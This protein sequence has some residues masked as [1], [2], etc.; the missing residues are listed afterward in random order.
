[1]FCCLLV[2][3]VAHQISKKMD[4]TYASHLCNS[5][6]GS[7]HCGLR[8]SC[9]WDPS[10]F[11]MMWMGNYYFKPSLKL[12]LFRLPKLP[13]TIFSEIM[14]G[15]LKGSPS[16]PTLNWSM[17]PHKKVLGEKIPPKIVFWCYVHE[18]L[19]WMLWELCLI[20]C[21]SCAG[22]CSYPWHCCSCFPEYLS[23]LVYY[24]FFPIFKVAFKDSLLLFTGLASLWMAILSLGF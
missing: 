8:K 4:Q 21:S 16:V 18:H 19:H 24:C 14:S 23:D 13:I 9:R 17:K 20:P 15:D 10:Q 22:E 2:N 7:T 1:M 11:G 12:H 5:V 3:L 6:L